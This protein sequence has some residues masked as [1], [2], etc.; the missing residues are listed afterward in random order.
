[1]RPLHVGLAV[2]QEAERLAVVADAPLVP[3]RLFGCL[4][5]HDVLVYPP[6]AGR[7]LEDLIGGAGEVA[8]DTGVQRGRRV[9]RRPEPLG[10]VV[11]NV[12]LA[13]LRS[14]AHPGGAVGIA[15]QRRAGGQRVEVARRARRGRGRVGWWWLAWD[16]AGEPPHRVDDGVHGGPVHGPR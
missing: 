12:H 10:L 3:P 14:A 11:R 13:Y 16:R 7:P 2:L 15:G 1:E 6:L 4:G 9:G 8:G 5:P